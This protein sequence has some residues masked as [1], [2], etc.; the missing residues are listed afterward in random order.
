VKDDGSVRA[1]AIDLD[2]AGTR[3]RIICP[4]RSGA[5]F[6]RGALADHLVGEPA[7]IGFALQPPSSSNGFHV[8]IDRTGSILARLGSVE[9]C[10]SVLGSHLAA[11][12]P[13]PPDT[14]RLRAR[15]LLRSDG[16]AL[17]AV[18][19]LL[20]RHPLIE[21]RLAACA[22]R[23]VDRL[24]VDIGPDLDLWMSATPWPALRELP[25]A[26]GHTGA[27]AVPTPIAGVLVPATANEIASPPETAS[28]L[29]AV[30]CSGSSRQHRLAMA[31]RLATSDP[32]ALSVSDV[33]GFYAVLQS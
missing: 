27:P 3:L 30:T 14:V 6:L 10:L 19:P 22:V 23:V 11:F 24:V 21:R 17:L 7:P 20:Y 8:L 12:V 16:T 28:F 31:E 13:P 18:H 25:R 4:D 5:D 2:L 33:A 26:L 32:R 15:A 1:D 9:E 29:A